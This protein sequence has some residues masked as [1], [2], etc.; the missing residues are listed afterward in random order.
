MKVFTPL[1]DNVPVPFLVKPP[2]PLITPVVIDVA[3]EPSMVN[4]KPP[5]F[6]SPV[7]VIPP[8]PEDVTVAAAVR[9]IGLAIAR[10]EVELLNKA[11]EE[12]TP[13]PA[14]SILDQ[15]FKV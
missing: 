1:K 4:K 6:I 13:V 10:A 3:F 11:P 5:L 15:V 9:V 14:K 2:A 8:V 12:D 7:R